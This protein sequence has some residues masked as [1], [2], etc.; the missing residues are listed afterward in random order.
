MAL[1]RLYCGIFGKVAQS[2]RQLLQT[3]RE[4]PCLLI[5]LIMIS[6]GVFLRWKGLFGDLWLDE[7][8]T[9]T[10]IESASSLQE[11]WTTI[12]FDGFASLSTL[13][14]YFVGKGQPTELYRALSF[15]SGL[16][17]MAL[18]LLWFR[19]DFLKGLFTICLYSFSYIF[20]LYDSEARGYA[21]MLTLALLS[22]ITLKKITDGNSSALFL[23]AYWGSTILA[24]FSHFSFLLFFLALVLW[25]A[26]ELLTRYPVKI[27]FGKALLQHGVP[28][29]LFSLFYLFY[30]SN[31]PSAGGSFSSNLDV[32]ISTVSIAFGG[33]LLTANNLALTNLMVTL[34]MIIVSFLLTEIILLRK[35]GDHAYILFLTSIVLAPA[36]VIFVLQPRYVTIRYF[37]PA[38]IMMHFLM[39]SFL[40]R[41]F[42]QG[43]LGMAVSCFLLFAF[44]AGNFGY[45]KDFMV[46]GRGQ[47]SATL[48][49]I[50]ANDAANT[51]FISSDYDFRNQT[52][53]TYH[54]NTVAP[55]KIK[56]VNDKNDIGIKPGWYLIHSEDR[57]QLPETY[58]R[59]NRG[60]LFVF[61]KG[62]PHTALSGWSWFVYK[63]KHYVNSS[64]RN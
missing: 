43:V 52:V 19:R 15:V 48:K 34:A 44:L 14:L 25:S 62:F 38:I 55:K 24:F 8:W 26:A 64:R 31:L 33:N 57:A 39:A 18:L 16:L 13:F 6:S 17:T 50:A 40:A 41:L 46:F 60:E 30:V 63:R 11:L 29:L 61:E 53:I 20:I 1:R 59:N 9:L 21:P 5:M 4:S 32:I 28:T 22:M 42:R 23:F 7:I 51:I 10:A 12:K 54:S 37:L 45:L 56:Y 27:A 2:V 3:T 58:Y 36:I 49:Y 35:E 47:Y